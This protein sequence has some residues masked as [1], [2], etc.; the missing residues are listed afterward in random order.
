MNSI[1]VEELDCGNCEIARFHGKEADV[2]SVSPRTETCYQAD[3]MDELAHPSEVRSSVSEVKH[4]VVRRNNTFLP[5]EASSRA[6]PVDRPRR[7]M[8]PG[9]GDEE[10]AE[11]IVVAGKPGAKYRP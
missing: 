5:G 9:E 10:S 4:G 2:K 8:I 7:G 11:V 3:G 1:N 6:V